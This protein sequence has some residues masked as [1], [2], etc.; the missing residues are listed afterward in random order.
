MSENIEVKNIERGTQC[1]SRHMGFKLIKNS[2]YPSNCLT[3][4]NTLST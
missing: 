1:K 2:N 4:A 3:K